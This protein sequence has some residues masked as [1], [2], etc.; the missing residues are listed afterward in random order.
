MDA[1]G[2]RME[3]EH[4]SDEWLMWCAARGERAALSPLLR[5]YAS[6]LLTFLRRM[7]G[8]HHRSEEL[9]QE[10]FLA[11]WAGRGKYQYP[12]PFRPWLFGIALNKCRADHRLRAGRPAP[13]D[14][15]D[16]DPAV[17]PGRSPVE[18]AVAAETAALV[19]AAVLRLSPRQR[20]VVAL[21]VWNGLSYAEIAATLGCEESTVRSNM[22]HGLEAIR[23]HLETRL[24]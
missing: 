11:V 16:G 6:P 17:A 18:A 9:F 14:A 24:R 2:L 19:Q 23:K 12:R 15:R 10:T 7:S 1:G 22:F 13:G 3:Q 21:R 20:A 8:D 5:R 4:A